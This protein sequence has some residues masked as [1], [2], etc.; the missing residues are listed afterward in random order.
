MVGHDGH[1]GW[2]Y[3]LAVQPVSQRQGI[4]RALMAACERWVQD[5]GIPK[6]QLM[7]RSTNAGVISF[8]EEL[9]YADSDVVV[10]GRFFP[11]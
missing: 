11:D 1:R 3:Y 10:L 7:V 2:V 9:G 8:Y 4:G 6:I 5:H